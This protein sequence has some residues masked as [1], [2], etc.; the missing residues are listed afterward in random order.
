M[1]IKRKKFGSPFVKTDYWMMHFKRNEDTR[2]FSWGIFSFR[3]APCIAGLSGMWELI[4]Q[5]EFILKQQCDK[6]KIQKKSPTCGSTKNPQL[7]FRACVC[8]CATST[9]GVDRA[10]WPV[11]RVMSLSKNVA[12]LSL[13]TEQVMAAVFQKDLFGGA[14]LRTD[15]AGP[16]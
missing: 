3:T 14:E 1:N 7:W 9:S 10:W 16:T 11:Y 13:T 12:F 8:G 15:G 4:S 2:T 6:F 5:E